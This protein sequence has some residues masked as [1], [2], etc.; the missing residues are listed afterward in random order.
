MTQRTSN[1]ERAPECTEIVN[2]LRAFFGKDSKVL[3]VK[4]NDLKIGDENESYRP[5]RRAAQP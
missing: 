3:Y 4:E 5:E 2:L 1:Q